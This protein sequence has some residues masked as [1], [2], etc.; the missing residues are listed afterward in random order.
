MS[1]EEPKTEEPKKE[2][3]VTYGN[4]ATTV[5]LNELSGSPVVVRLEGGVE[6]R[7]QLSAIDSFL[8]VV[9]RD[10]RET[11]E[12]TEVASLG[13]VF[14]RGSAITYVALE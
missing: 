10:T 1:T 5:F 4:N 7:G 8:N 11:Y 6:Y 2:Q 14:L 3:R 12:G 9:L 13:E